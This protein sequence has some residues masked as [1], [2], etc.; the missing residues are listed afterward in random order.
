MAADKEN[1]QEAI[2][3]FNMQS[4]QL[5]LQKQHELSSIFGSGIEK[6]KLTSM[7]TKPYY[8][9]SHTGE[10]AG[11]IHDHPDT[12]YIGIEE[13]AVLINGIRFRTKHIDF[14]L[15]QPKS[16]DPTFRAVQDIPPPGVP[17]NV[18]SN[19]PIKDQI[20]E[21]K[22]CFKAWQDQDQTDCDYKKYFKP[23]LCYLEATWVVPKTKG[24]ED[25]YQQVKYSMHTGYKEPNGTDHLPKIFLGDFTD[26]KKPNQAKW[27][28]RVMCYPFRHDIPLARFE[29][30][31][32][33]SV[34]VPYK[35]TLDQYRDSKKARFLIKPSESL[36]KSFRH[37]RYHFGYLDA[38]M[39]QIPGLDNING[40]TLRDDTCGKTTLHIRTGAPLQAQKYHRWFT[41][42]DPVTKETKQAHRGFSDNGIFMA[43]NTRPEVFGVD[44]KCICKKKPCY[45]KVQRWS[46]AIPFEIIYQTP[47]QSWDPYKLGGKY[48]IPAEF[49][50]GGEVD[51]LEDDTAKDFITINGKKVSASGIRT[52]FPNIPGVGA[53]IRQ[54]YPIFPISE[55]NR[56]EY[57]STAA[58]NDLIF[59]PQDY[60]VIFKV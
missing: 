60:S 9:D 34:R 2:N 50:Q 36:A 58:L 28:Y 25:E 35:L 13:L 17:P 44:I 19:L 39:G 3:L 29:V 15:Q 27:D 45:S 23:V 30:V 10:S 14:K 42:E 8:S 32:D 4:M 21:M 54:R 51:R 53:R 46:Y 18:A 22:K 33:L 6:K 26:I 56:R 40:P 55:A 16:N 24:W 48:T 7:G 47:L 1:L 49:F 52:L 57:Q 38:L 41:I 11:G 31:D 59:K 5:S 43:M 37:Q 12:D 20:T